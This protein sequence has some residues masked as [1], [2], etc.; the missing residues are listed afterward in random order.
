MNPLIVT[1]AFDAGTRARLD[2]LR[3]RWFPPE[4][5]QLAAHVTL[6]HALPGD[7]LDQLVTLLGRVCARDAPA[8][9]VTEVRSLGRGAA[10]VVSS[11][12]LGEVRAEVA[13]EFAGRLS[14]Q[15]GQGF[16]AHVTVQN[17]VTPDVAWATLATLSQGFEPWPLGVTG[18][19]VHRYLGGPWELLTEVPFTP[20]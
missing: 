20:R 12:E 10:L 9:E 8:A 13:A 4:R 11:P 17:F 19:A 16:R 3:E 5:N 7:A 6:F 1:A 15:D 2:G 18:L 14:R